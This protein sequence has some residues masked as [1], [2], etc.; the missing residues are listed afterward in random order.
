MADRR[1]RALIIGCGYLGSRVAMMLRDAG[2]EVTATSRDGER[3]RVLAAQGL[4]PVSLDLDRLEDSPAAL[5]KASYDLVLYSVAPGRAGNARLGFYEGAVRS[6]ELLRAAPPRRFVYISSTGVYAQRD[7][8]EVDEES[9]AE[10]ENERHRLIR[11]AEDALLGAENRPPATVL[12]LGGLYGPGRSPVDWLRR[13][14]FRLRPRGGSGAYMN[15]VRVEDAARAV[16]AAGRRGK[17]GRIYLVVDGAPVRRRDFYGLAAEL[18]GTEPPD[19]AADPGDLG[20]RCSNRRMVE[21][22]G[23]TPAYPDY[24]RGLRSLED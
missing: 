11:E 12:R 22:L 9:A 7:G 3:L 5:W 18:A 16:V 23:V 17:S 6:L 8:S 4:T 2:Y 14:D 1:L 10:P 21:E 24:R 15:W 19:F 20:K 13:P